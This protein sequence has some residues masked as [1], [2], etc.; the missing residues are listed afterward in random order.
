MQKGALLIAA[1][2]AFQF[3]L[4]GVLLKVQ[5][6][7]A[8]AQR[9]EELGKAVL[10]EA[11]E[12]ERAL[13]EAQSGLRGMAMSRDPGF[14]QTQRDA[15]GS[16]P[17]RVARLREH[18]AEESDQRARLERIA[19]AAAAHAAWFEEAEELGVRDPD[20]LA[21]L[22]ETL[23]GKGLMD[24]AQGELEAFLEVQRELK[25]AREARS[26]EL[27][28][29]LWPLMLAAGV[30]SVGVAAATLWL[31]GRSF[32]RRIEVVTENA[33]RL[34]AGQ[35]LAPPIRGGDEVA[36]L[37]RVLHGTAARLAEA[38]EELRRRAEELEEANA[39]LRQTTQENET[40]VYSVSHDL[41]S[42]LVNLQGFT[43]ELEHSCE[44]LRAAIAGADLPE[45][46]RKRVDDVI[47]RDMRESVAFIQAAV[48]RSSAIIDVLLRLSR[49]GRVQYAE[50]E[51]DLNPI[52]HRIVS[53]LR[54]TA[55]EK[56]AE[57]RIGA[58]P[59]VWGDPTAVEQV[60]ANLVGNAV[61]YLDPS[62]PGRI[63]IED[64]GRRT[65]P[66][67]HRE[68]GGWPTAVFCVRDNGMGIPADHMDKLFVAFQRLHG[69]AAQGEGVGLALVKRIV[70]RHGG[71]IWAESAPGEGTAFYVALPAA[72]GDGAGERTSDAG[73]GAAARPAAA[74]SP[75]EA[76]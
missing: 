13:M 69:E 46:V 34:A 39:D 45:A 48:T 72:K 40:F 41:R 64:A 58:L 73:A 61:N 32:A 66:G 42:P 14:E 12:I 23:E 43:R 30:L 65:P 35:E 71:R 70:D 24:A 60:L 27:R 51:V 5:A 63:V 29:G 56:G 22:L 52:A 55:A 7:A 31:F 33:D 8:E 26:T 10:D 16:V 28:R 4:I 20:A 57:I 25:S 75:A 6:D 68:T 2:I 21:A 50:R 49:A 54:A 15:L 76:R 3:V 44:D 11:H 62:R 9:Q 1:P 74:S 37:D 47:D 19:T 36:R 67:P 17:A 59:R 18:L 38:S 53:A